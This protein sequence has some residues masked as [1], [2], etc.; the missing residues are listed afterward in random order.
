MGTP[1]LEMAYGVAGRLHLNRAGFRLTGQ[2]ICSSDQVC[3][4]DIDV[5]FFKQGESV[6]AATFSLADG[7]LVAIVLEDARQHP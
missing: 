3:K 2:V 5:Q 7:R 6:L 1:V 4:E